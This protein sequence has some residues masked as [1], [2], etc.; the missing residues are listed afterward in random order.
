MM[1]SEPTSGTR[2][3][4]V[5]TSHHEIVLVPGATTPGSMASFG[6]GDGTVTSGTTRTG[7]RMT[8]APAVCKQP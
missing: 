3:P 5:I 4:V 2:I 6:S 1:L 8:R 7:K